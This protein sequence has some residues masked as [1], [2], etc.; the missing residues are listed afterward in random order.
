MSEKILEVRF[1]RSESGD[2][3]VRQWLLQLSHEARKAIGQDIKTVEFGWPLGMPL[4][5]KMESDL[6]EVR[7][8]IPDGIART[9]FSVVDDEMILLHGFVK[10]SKKT[11]KSELA[12]ARQRLSSIKLE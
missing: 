5:R 1:F 6:W 7:S 4:I 3:P 8:G 2:E 9:M 11:P 10:K 12:I